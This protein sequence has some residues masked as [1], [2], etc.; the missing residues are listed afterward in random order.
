MFEDSWVVSLLVE[1]NGS[2][3]DI[4]V[5]NDAGVVDILR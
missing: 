3:V 2:S 1:D 4:N 5:G